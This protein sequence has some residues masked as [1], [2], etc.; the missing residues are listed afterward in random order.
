MNNIK[1]IK[2]IENSVAIIEIQREKH[3]NA[4]NIEV[5]QELEQALC[6]AREDN[7]IRSIIITGSG[8]RAF[9]AGADIKEFQQFNKEEAQNLSQNGKQKVFDKIANFKKPVIAAI[10]GYALG[11]GLELALAA[12]IRVASNTSKLGLPECSL[13]LIPGYGG[14]QRLPQIIGTG[15]ASEMILT[16][17]IISAEQAQAI[18]LVNHVFTAEKLIPEALEIAKVFNKKSPES[19]CAAIKSINN[20]FAKNGNSIESEEF[21]KLFETNNFKEG[22]LAFLEKRKPTFTT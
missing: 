11:G 10:N 2:K 22:V 7:K 19:L 6:Q 17:K 12:H 3:L 18:G 16:G 4:L 9:V 14:T 21:S 8:K 1:Y 15:L 13:G 5:I 20:C